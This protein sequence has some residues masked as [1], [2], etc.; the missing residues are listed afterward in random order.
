[1]ST[2]TKSAESVKRQIAFMKE[3]RAE[4]YVV[5]KQ[6]RHHVAQGKNVLV[7]AEEKSGKRIIVEILS[8][9]DWRKFYKHGGPTPVNIYVTGLVRNDCKTQLSE[10]E[11]DYG[12][13][14]YALRG[15]KGAQNR[16]EQLDRLGTMRG[17]TKIHGDECDYA[18]G[19]KQA[20]SVFWKAIKTRDGCN[21]ILYS[22]TSEECMLSKE[23]SEGIETVM[24][25]PSSTYRGAEWYLGEGLVS[26]SEC[27]WDSA[28]GTW[29]AHG[30]ALVDGLIENS[31]S[32]DAE[33]CKKRVG[34]VRL[35]SNRSC[36]DYP[37]C[38]AALYGKEQEGI[39]VMF[40]DEKNPFDWG[41]EDAW[42][43]NCSIHRRGAADVPKALLIV[44]CA[45]CTRSTEL[46]GHPY[47]KFWHDN[48]SLDTCA[49]STLS[50]ALGRIKHYGDG[51]NRIQVY[52][53]PRVFK[54]NCGEMTLADV[55]RVA[56]RTKSKS[57]SQKKTNPIKFE[58]NGPNSL[59]WHDNSDNPNVIYRKDHISEMERNAEQ[60]WVHK[61]SP[62]FRY[63]G[64]C[65][66]E[67]DSALNSL[68]VTQNRT[69][70][71]YE[72]D[73]EESG[74]AMRSFVPVITAGNDAVPTIVQMKYAHNTSPLS[75]YE[76]I[77]DAPPP[78]MSMIDGDIRGMGVGV[79]KDTIR[80][81][82]KRMRGDL[83]G[84]KAVLQKTL[85]DMRRRS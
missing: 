21:G 32:P 60:K 39:N 45:T 73:T 20:L 8:L 51:S 83:G 40:V 13:Q 3:N 25:V 41:D 54:L 82:P 57:I 29:T 23:M 10:M 50:Q 71:V 37:M 19:G 14:A 48:R 75:M 26:K 28:E 80:K 79:L 46:A 74:W 69:F 6:I 85:H 63:L 34:V 1:M 36:K 61:S 7:C 72:N 27:F 68:G 44:I 35:L 24:F 31:H 70:L 30:Q 15:K 9:L 5:A 76:R 18:S 4:Q 49:Y 58:D 62:V 17:N 78:N 38:F 64:N 2:H 81:D 43:S 66:D 77:D 55:K 12:V 56:G 52:S 22:A 67:K 42:W 33:V 11:E 53:D 16:L 47:I 65:R 84:S 59:I